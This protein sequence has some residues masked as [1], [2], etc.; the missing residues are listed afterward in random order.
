MLVSILIFIHVSSSWYKNCVPQHKT[1]WDLLTATTVN[2]N[3][4]FQYSVIL[5]KVFICK[6]KNFENYFMS[7]KHI[8]TYKYKN[9]YG[10][11]VICIILYVFKNTTKCFSIFFK[12]ADHIWSITA[13]NDNGIEIQRNINDLKTN[14]LDQMKF[15]MKIGMM[16]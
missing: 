12:W 14:M 10:D 15:N 13:R 11:G 16:Q 2:G 9:N 4:T 7:V 1:S 5:C 3:L 8:N 6:M